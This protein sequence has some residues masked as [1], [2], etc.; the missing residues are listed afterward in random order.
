MLDG[1]DIL[2]VDRIRSFARTQID[3]DL[4]LAPG[5]R[6]PAYCTAMGK[7]LLANLSD[8]ERYRLLSSMNLTKRTNDTITS[9]TVLSQKLDQ[10][11]DQGLAVNNQELAPDV[12]SVAAPVRDHA[13][14]VVAAVNLAA[15]TS[16][17]SLDELNSSIRSAPT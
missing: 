5:T 4:D 14:E 11:R 13:R 8:A 9:K 7:V 12:H 1:E 3:T 17:I 2:Y 6:L 16:A 15:A 10:I